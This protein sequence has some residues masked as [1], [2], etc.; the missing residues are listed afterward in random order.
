MCGRSDEAVLRGGFSFFSSFSADILHIPCA[1]SFADAAAQ[2]DKLSMEGCSH[3]AL[4]GQPDNSPAQAI[5][6]LFPRVRADFAK[7]LWPDHYHAQLPASASEYV[8]TF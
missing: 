4:Q 7:P 2:P 1:I 5:N 3:H 8:R 6:K